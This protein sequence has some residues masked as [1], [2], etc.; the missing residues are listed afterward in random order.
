M[1]E[2]VGEFVGVTVAVFP[3]VFVGETVGELV[4]VFVGPVGTGVLVAAAGEEGELPQPCPI[5]HKLVKRNKGV[6][7][8][9]NFIFI[10]KIP[11]KGFKFKANRLLPGP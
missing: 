8:I 2:L 5:I 6:N 10:I 9:K 3:G 7:Q 11:P 1:G 4:G